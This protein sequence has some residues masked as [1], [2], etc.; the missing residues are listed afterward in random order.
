MD[1]TSLVWN[2]FKGAL[3]YCISNSRL[4][5]KKK[6]ERPTDPPDFFSWKGK[7]TIFFLAWCTCNITKFQSKL[8]FHS[9]L[10]ALLNGYDILIPISDA[11]RSDL[12][13]VSPE[14]V[15]F[16][17]KTL[18]IALEAFMKCFVTTKGINLSKQQNKIGLLLLQQ[19]IC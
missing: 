1:S 7:Q 11:S 3:V 19:W 17:S 16:Y 14:Q 18:L 2:L 10:V 4:K 5:S 12:F 13:P 15:T 8:A 9:G 6:K